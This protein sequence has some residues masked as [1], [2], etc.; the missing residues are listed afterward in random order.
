MGDLNFYGRVNSTQWKILQVFFSTV[1]RIDVDSSWTPFHSSLYFPISNIPK[2]LN[3]IYYFKYL[4]A[5]CHKLNLKLLQLLN[6]D[7][8]NYSNY[9]TLI[10]HCS[11]SCSSL[12]FSLAINVLKNFF[13][14]PKLTYFLRTCASWRFPHFISSFDNEKFVN[15]LQIL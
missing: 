7:F 13:A 15:V 14:N 9:G 8:P 11:L 6:S 12:S 4:K 3:S 10:I 1:Q 5:N 2:L